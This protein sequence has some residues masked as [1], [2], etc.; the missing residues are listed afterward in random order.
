MDGLNGDTENRWIGI[1]EKLSTR[2]SNPCHTAMQKLRI[3][4]LRFRVGRSLTGP[5]RDARRFPS[6][7]WYPVPGTTRFRWGLGYAIVQGS[8][9]LGV[10]PCQTPTCYDSRLLHR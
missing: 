9:S 8:F 10:A 2:R 6:T 1:R 3:V 5:L 7:R 4:T